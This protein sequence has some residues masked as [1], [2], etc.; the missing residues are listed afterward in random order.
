MTKELSIENI[1]KEIIDKLMNNMDILNY[2]KRYTEDGVK[3]SQFHNSLIWDY[4]VSGFGSDY[5]SVEVAEYEINR[6]INSDYK[7]YD[8]SIKMSLIKE[9]NICDMA[10]TISNIVKSLYPNGNGFSNVPF[11]TKEY[12]NTG[13]EYEKLHRAITFNIIE[14]EKTEDK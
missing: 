14:E 1:K 13:L 10:K 8:V 9:E 6:P 7:R 3:I 5:I 2:F 4:D 12:M 11:K